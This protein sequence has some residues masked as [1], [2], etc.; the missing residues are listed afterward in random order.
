MKITHTF[1][2]RGQALLTSGYMTSGLPEDPAEVLSAAI[3]LM[4]VLLLRP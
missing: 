1:T 4:A 3:T 2:T